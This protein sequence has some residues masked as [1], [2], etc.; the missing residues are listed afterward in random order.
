[1]VSEQEVFA[2][3]KEN[4][5]FCKI[6]KGDVPAKKV[7]EDEL[8]IAILDINPAKKGHVLVMPKE[9]YPILPLVP[10]EDMQHVFRKTKKLIDA[11]KE[12]MLCQG[13]SLFI[14]NGGAAGQQSPHFLFH[15]IPRDKNDMFTA[16]NIP[17]AGNK[18]EN[19]SLASVAAP[20]L[21]SFMQ[22]YLNQ[23][24]RQDKAIK[25]K[26]EP[27]V[28]ESVPVAKPSAE[29]VQEGDLDKLIEVINGNDDLKDALINRPD[30]VKEAIRTQEKWQRL[31]KG[32]DVDKLSENL[33]VMVL[34]NAK[35]QQNKDEL[36]KVGEL[37]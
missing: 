34:A 9:H 2:Q 12:A 13:V 11:L 26:D 35:Q 28:E 21:Q 8:L 16:F 6:I 22:A 25:P 31:F 5:I 36:D 27:L 19:D 10:F 24:G 23:L 30:E 1:M 7:Y 18:E 15:L 3:Q 20:K 37:L 32:V 29:P 4:C 17:T 14:A 33:R